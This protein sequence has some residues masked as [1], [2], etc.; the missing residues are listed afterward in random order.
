M[1]YYIISYHII[2]Y[3]VISYRIC[4]IVLFTDTHTF[5]YIYICI[6][7]HFTPQ[8]LWSNVIFPGDVLAIPRTEVCH[9]AA[10]LQQGTAGF[11]GGPVTTR[12]VKGVD[13]MGEHGL[14]NPLPWC[15]LLLILEAPFFASATN[16][17]WPNRPCLLLKL[18]NH[19]SFWSTPH[20][21]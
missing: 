14:D 11:R 8:H 15:L 5:V 10:E 17:C 2:L 9:R 12:T 19:Q 3:Y 16:C 18:W 20:F 21:A 13:F 6:F 1:L 4:Y 7:S